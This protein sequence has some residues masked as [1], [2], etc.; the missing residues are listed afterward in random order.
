[1]I[2]DDARRDARR[3]FVPNAT[4][5]AKQ[6]GP[7]RMSRLVSDMMTSNQDLW[8]V[9]HDRFSAGKMTVKGVAM[10]VIDNGKM[11]I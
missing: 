6:T 10:P 9:R 1:V 5:C 7:S 11:M 3:N 2:S 4:S 8:S